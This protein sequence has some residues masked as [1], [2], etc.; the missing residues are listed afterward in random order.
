MDGREHSRLQDLLRYS[1]HRC[2]KLVEL[3]EDG[4]WVFNREEVTAFVNSEMASMLGYSPEEMLGMT[5]RQFASEH[6]PVSRAESLIGLLRSSNRQQ[7]EIK[8][9]HKDGSEVWVNVALYSL[10][11]ERGEFAGRVGIFSNT[12][13]RKRA[14]RALRESERRYHDLF[15]HAP[16]GIYRTTGDGLISMAN[17]ALVFM[18]GYT[19][20]EE[21]TGQNLGEEGCGPI[22]QREAFRAQ[23]E[24]DGE[25]RGVESVWKRQDKSVLFVRE[26][27]KV[28]R[29]PSGKILYFEGT[30][31]D[32]TEQKLAEEKLQQSEARLRSLINNAPYGIYQCDP[33]TDR[34]LDVNPA[35][36]EMLG[37]SSKQELLA[38]EI[39]KDIYL[40]PG[41][42]VLFVEQCRLA[43]RFESDMTWKRRDGKRLN[44]RVRGRQ[45]READD[46]LHLE[47]Y[48]EDI[49]KRAEL[50]QQLRQAQKMEAVGNL[51]G[52]VAHDFNNLLMIISSYTQMLEDEL[53]PGHRLRHNT[54]QV[55]KAVDRSGALIQQLLAFS[56]KQILSPRILDLNSVVEETAKMIRRLIGE[57]I[58]LVLSLARPLWLVKADPDQIGQVLMNLCVNGRDA[59]PKGGKLTIST[60]SAV[61]DQEAEPDM[62]GVVSGRYTILTVSD[63]GIGMSKQVQS[64]IFEPFFTT[65][66]MGKGTGLGLSMV[67]GIV[68]Q[69]GGYIWVD[70]E[71]DK[72][73]TFEVRFPAVDEAI[74]PIELDKATPIAGQG[75]TILLAEDEDALRE[76]VAAYLVQHGYRVL[77]ASNGDEALQV[78]ARYSGDIHLL[79]TDVVM[80]KL[81]GTELARELIKARPGLT[82]LFMSGYTDHRLLELL[83][84]TR[85]SSILQKPLNLLTLLETIGSALK[86]TS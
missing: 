38:S 39:S 20:F 28:V 56:R 79:L 49:S 83:P 15:A 24:R 27:A 63:N 43:G 50:E 59:M 61:I 58:E 9:R 81:E 21:L 76:S 6:E 86:K 40:D 80:P 1:D 47:V 44:V 18:L 16:V 82:T 22:Y 71:L 75:E 35:L 68:K 51:A 7:S 11:D 19:S 25:T 85:K 14:E 64:R 73:T 48:V 10:S 26:N 45:S 60:H 12:T 53:A 29:D 33:R 67:Y 41:E 72:G 17:E 34:F 30:V 4:V 3:A 13:A 36:V 23:I 70:S 84:Q 5:P 2:Q 74:T 62:P 32:I 46:G 54:R 55:L 8:L 31:E 57:D 52:G 66:P 37:Y 42:C 69:S 77:K 78:A 65:K